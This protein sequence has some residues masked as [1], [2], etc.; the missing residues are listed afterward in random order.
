MRRTN[1]PSR[2]QFLWDHDPDLILWS[3][4]SHLR[5]APISLTKRGFHSSI[6]LPSHW[7]GPPDNFPTSPSYQNTTFKSLQTKS[8]NPSLR[9]VSTYIVI[10][11]VTSPKSVSTSRKSMNLLSLKLTSL[12]TKVAFTCIWLFFGWINGEVTFWA[13][14]SS[15]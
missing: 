15:L 2:T 14:I 11:N 1:N 12:A 6:F 5:Y 3:I 4:D 7:F 9:S 13:I 10:L 8:T